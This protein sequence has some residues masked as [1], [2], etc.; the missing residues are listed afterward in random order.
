M[1]LCFLWS[2]YEMHGGI[3]VLQLCRCYFFNILLC[4]HKLAVLFACHYACKY[5]WQ[6]IARHNYTAQQFHAVHAAICLFQ[7]ADVSEGR[8]GGATAGSID[9]LAPGG[10]LYDFWDMS[11]RP[12]S[13]A[14]S[15]STTPH[16]MAS[17]GVLPAATVCSHLYALPANG[18]CGAH[19][20]SPFCCLMMV[21]ML[22]SV[23]RGSSWSRSHGQQ[24]VVVEQRNVT[25]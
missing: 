24:S 5:T 2:R 3:S 6:I 8:T 16:R 18:V 13:P 10:F 14:G 23:V 19:S 22:A 7:C 11:H 4:S 12:A 25:H 9:Q 1:Q 17:A 15:W 20:T 21:T